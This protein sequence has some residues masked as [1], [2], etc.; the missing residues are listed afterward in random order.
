MSE[1]LLL[2]AGASVEAE[3]PDTYGMTS[4]IADLFRK[5][6]RFERH[7]HVVSFGF[8]WEGSPLSA[9]SVAFWC[10]KKVRW[11]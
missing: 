7:A 10:A 2:G 4:R 11:F 6:R 9:L 3:V 8:S 1:M 5:D